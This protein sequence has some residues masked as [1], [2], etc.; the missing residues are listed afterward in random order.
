MT[1][2]FDLTREPWIP[3][4]PV[5]GPQSETSLRELFVGAHELRDLASTSP[6]ENVA[7]LCLLL[8]ILYDLRNPA[9]ESQFEDDWAGLWEAGR[10]PVTEIGAYFE[11]RRDCFDLFHGQRPFYQIPGLVVD[12]KN[13]VSRLITEAASGNRA[14]LFDRRADANPDPATPAVAAR[15]LLVSQGFAVA[16]GRAATAHFGGV[17]HPRPDSADAILLRGLTIWLS[18]ENLFETLLLN[19]SPYVRSAADAPA[20]D[21]E[22]LHALMDRLQGGSRVTVAARGRLDRLTWQS[23]L[24]RLLPE[25]DPDG[26]IV[27]R[28][29]YFSQGRSA[30]KAGHPM[31]TYRCEDPEKGF[32]PLGLSPRKAAWRDAHALFQMK[33]TDREQPAAAL[34]WASEMRILGPLGARHTVG[35]NIVGLATAPNKAS[36]LLMWRQERMPLPVALIG[37]EYN[38]LLGE[39]RNALALAENEDRRMR[40]QMSRVVKLY[41]A[42]DLD[43]PGGRQPDPREVNRLLG[44]VDPR[45]A[46]WPRLEAPF[47]RFLAELAA[48]QTRAA[49][50]WEE[51]VA[52]ERGRALREAEQALGSHPR[53]QAAVAREA[54]ERKR[55]AEQK[56]RGKST[57]GGPTK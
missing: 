52:R 22:P 57:K 19:Y 6:L 47:Y 3:V 35:F 28:H 20:W 5:D 51:A 39:I 18:G 38:A 33:T 31:K 12:R 17:Q 56:Q 44:A 27:V 9:D 40:S 1:S 8:A 21:V 25:I 55:Y 54:A 14:T 13:P 49:G 2:G 45:R 50:D 16:L 37:E 34:Q 26:R 24:V 46:F 4:T 11:A 41:L 30:D 42:P 48:D 43:R 7:I 15:A 32:L 53:V 23:R 29:V 10:F 36:K